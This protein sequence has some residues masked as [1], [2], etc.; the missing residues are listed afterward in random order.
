MDMDMGKVSV[1]KKFYKES[2]KKA[3]VWCSAVF[4]ELLCSVDV[5]RGADL[6]PLIFSI[7]KKYR[8]LVV[9]HHLKLWIEDD[10]IKRCQIV[11][12]VCYLIILILI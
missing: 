12:V 2:D 10:I 9:L 3:E 5:T 4:F 8:A 11:S 1:S 7:L 6:S